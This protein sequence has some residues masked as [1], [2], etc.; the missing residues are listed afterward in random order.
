MLCGFKS[1]V[2]RWTWKVLW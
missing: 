2:Q 1:T